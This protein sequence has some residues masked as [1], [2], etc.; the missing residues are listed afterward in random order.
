M[1][2]G[3][4]IHEFAPSHPQAGREH[5]IIR[6]LTYRS[7]DDDGSITLLAG[8]RVVEVGVAFDADDPDTPWMAAKVGHVVYMVP[9]EATYCVRFH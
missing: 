1:N 8:T 6:D 5:I 7:F 3:F 4:S 9:Y 2:D